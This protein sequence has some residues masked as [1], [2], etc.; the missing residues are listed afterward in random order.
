MDKKEQ[1]RE[2]ARLRK[3][4]QRERDTNVTQG[5]VTPQNVTRNVTDNVTLL[6]RPNGPDYDPTEKLYNNRHYPNGT[7][8][9][10]GPLSD[11][12]VLDRLTV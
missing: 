11:G 9:Y 6:H 3:Q 4:K 1:T 8:R 12:Q 7:P 5:D 2:A 10:L